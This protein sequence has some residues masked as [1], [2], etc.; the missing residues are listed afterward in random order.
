MDGCWRGDL[1]VV[2]GSVGGRSTG[3]GVVFLCHFEVVE[4]VR[5]SEGEERCVGDVL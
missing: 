1:G 3:G 2:V 4:C 5:W